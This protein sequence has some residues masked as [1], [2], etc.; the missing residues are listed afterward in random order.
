MRTLRFEPPTPP[1][2][3]CPLVPPDLAPHACLAIVP[4]PTMHSRQPLQTVLLYH[5]LAGASHHDWL[6]ESPDPTQKLLTCFRIVD[7]TLFSDPGQTALLIAL[8]PHRRVFLNYQG[9][10]QP[11][12]QNNRSIDRGLVIRSR[13]GTF[14]PQVWTDRLKLLEVQWPGRSALLRLRKI[15]ADRWLAVHLP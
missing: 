1:E 4:S 8:P 12:V 13:V 11:I 15:S 9:P 6:L 2:A 10:I 7:L 5:R 14:F 3:K